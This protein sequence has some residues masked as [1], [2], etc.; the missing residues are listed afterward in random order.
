MKI[1]PRCGIGTYIID[2][3]AASVR[4]IEIYNTPDLHADA[5]AELALAGTLTLMRKLSVC[6]KDI[7]TGQ[8]KQKM[9]RSLYQKKSELIGYGNIAR[10]SE[11]LLSPSTR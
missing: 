3:R 1:I 11:Q 4:G 5:V 10:P 8:W 9:D 7:R 6:D 2:L